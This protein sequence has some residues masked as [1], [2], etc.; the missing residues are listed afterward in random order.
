M[1]ESSELNSKRTDLLCA[2]AGTSIN[3]PWAVFVFQHR[4]CECD[5]RISP[6]SF[7]FKPSRQL[8]GAI[9]VLFGQFAEDVRYVKV[10]AEEL[11]M[12]LIPFVTRD[13]LITPSSPVNPSLEFAAFTHRKSPSQLL[14]RSQT[15]KAF[16]TAI[17]ARARRDPSLQSD[18]LRRRR[19]Q[20][21]TKILMVS[22]GQEFSYGGQSPG[23]LQVR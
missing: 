4:L 12:L 2:S 1:H 23:L 6:G 13:I 7:T 19:P 3:S 17:S 22:L 14:P 16:A 18:E 20:L 9:V 8:D 15:S 21:P 11:R 5:Y 10:L